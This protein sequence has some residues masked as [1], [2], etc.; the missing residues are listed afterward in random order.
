MKRLL[1]QKKVGW[2]EGNLSDTA[3]KLAAMPKESTHPRTVIFTHGKEPTIVCSNGV[4]KLVP[5]KPIDKSLI[6]DTNGAGDAFVGGLLAGLSLGYPLEKCVTAGQYAA[7]EVIQQDG[8]VYPP[9][10]TFSWQ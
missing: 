4:V 10:C 2:P 5:V 8:P 7:C 1:L 6:V 3:L 9:N